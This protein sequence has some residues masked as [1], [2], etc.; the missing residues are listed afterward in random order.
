MALI[1]KDAPN[2]KNKFEKSI[3]YK[4]VSNLNKN[5]NTEQLE[6]DWNIGDEIPF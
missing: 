1:S 6:L 3:N 5:N 4:K 2:L